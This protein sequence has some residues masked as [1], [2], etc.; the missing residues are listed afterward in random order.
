MNE[1]LISLS[2]EVR[3]NA[4]FRLG[5]FIVG[6][7]LLLA[8]LGPWIT[9]Y[10][11]T[12]AQPSDFLQAPNMQHWLGTDRY[13]MDILSR[14]LHSP[15]I[16]M[17]IA[18]GATGLSLLFGVPIGV[19]A[20]YMNGSRGIQ[21]KISEFVMRLMDIVQAFPPFVI[22]MAFVAVIG[23]NI[24][25]V[26]LVIALINIPVFTRLTRSKVLSE[27]NRAY[28]DAA[29]CTGNTRGQILF[30]Y[31][32]PNS[33]APALINA[34]VVMGFSVMLTAGLSF[35]GAGIRV[36]EAELGSMIS[37]GAQNMVTGQYWTSLFPGIYLGLMIFGFALVGDGLRNGLDS[38]RKRG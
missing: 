33:L 30:R 21:G 24:W 1:S 31:L 29:I 22:A 3:V 7:M 15:R 25:N 11:P 13:G 26:M 8:L 9:P 16:D 28:I 35:I 18:L 37:I 23:P 12:E 27:K 6:G 5:L 17:S 38:T 4:K 32:L 34:S 36:P 19:W 2:N 10:H 20:G 14:V